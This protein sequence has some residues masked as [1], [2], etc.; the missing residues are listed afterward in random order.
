MFLPCLQITYVSAAPNS[1]GSITLPLKA[2]VTGDYTVVLS[3]D[4]NTT[5]SLTA[6]DQLIIPDGFF[7]EDTENIFQI[8]KPDTGVLNNTCYS[9]T[10]S[11]TTISQEVV[12]PTAHV[13]VNLTIDGTTVSGYT[14]TDFIGCSHIGLF[15]EGQGYVT[16]YTFDNTT[17]AFGWT[18]EE[19]QKVTIT[20]FK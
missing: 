8:R 3:D 14:D 6:G 17:G 13:E 12:Y 1:D 5:L 20:G 19:L 2:P 15:V 18:F 10:Y 11:V 4:S 9:L 7:T 16:P